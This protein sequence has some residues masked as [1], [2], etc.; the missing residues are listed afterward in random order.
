MSAPSSDSAGGSLLSLPSRIAR[1][2][3]VSID[4]NIFD[5][6]RQ[7]RLSYLPLLMVYMAAG[8]SSLTAIVGT[9]CPTPAPARPGG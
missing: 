7:M 6:G 5:L 3:A 4:R 9:L 8:V 2:L 1:A